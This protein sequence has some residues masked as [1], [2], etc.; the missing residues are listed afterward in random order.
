MTDLLL[1]VPAYRQQCHV[2]HLIQTAELV[3]AL[4]PRMAVTWADTCSLDWARN[5]IV[6]TALWQAPAKWL[7]MCDADTY[8][9]G[10]S[11]ILAML[12]E[13]ERRS[14]AVIG[15]AVRVRSTSETPIYNPGQVLPDGT[16]RN[17][18]RDEFVGRV[19]QVDRIGTA[20]LALNMAFFRECWPDGPWFQSIQVARGRDAPGWTGEDYAFCDQVRK[21]RGAVFV[22]GRY[23][24]VHAGVVSET[25]VMRGLGAV[26]TPA[27]S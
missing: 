2:G 11:E 9:W 3:K 18:T 5:V 16:E 26:V 1:A 10:S 19:V 13:G 4:G 14:A 17:L 7:L 15:A 27:R 6:W 23:E 24:P 8:H 20:F 25:A 22:D 12:D 21:R